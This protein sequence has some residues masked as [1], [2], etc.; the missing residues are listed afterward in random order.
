MYLLDLPSLALEKI[1]KHLPTKDLAS[2]MMTCTTLHTLLRPRQSA[3]VCA[4]SKGRKWVLRAC[5]RALFADVASRYKTGVEN[6]E[7]PAPVHNWEPPLEL[8]QIAAQNFPGHVRV[9]TYRKTLNGITHMDSILTRPGIFFYMYRL[10]HA[11]GFGTIVRMLEEIWE[12]AVS[13]IPGAKPVVDLGGTFQIIRASEM[14]DFSFRPLQFFASP[15]FFPGPV[16]LSHLCG[17]NSDL[18]EVGRF[19]AKAAT[20]MLGP[21]GL[22]VLFYLGFL[23]QLHPPVDRH[24]DNSQF[25]ALFKGMLDLTSQ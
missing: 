15:N 12:R 9:C 18:S 13:A 25:G 8:G 19:L 7:F 10:A 11:R 23:H 1:A 21:E 16:P 22:A 2:C 4:Q 5:S 20:T 17:G 3:M 14:P 24:M 6:F